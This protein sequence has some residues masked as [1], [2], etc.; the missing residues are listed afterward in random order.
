M[1]GWVV[2]EPGVQILRYTVSPTNTASIAL[3][4]SFG[5]NY[6]GEQIDEIDGPE[7]IYEMSANEYRNRILNR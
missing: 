1:W 3:V 5:F 4:N 7:S 2:T 6:V